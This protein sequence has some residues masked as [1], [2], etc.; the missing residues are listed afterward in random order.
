MNA[1]LRH[2]GLLGI[3]ALL[4]CATAA[5]AET[6]E[7]NGL[8]FVA[9]G[10][11]ATYTYD[12]STPKLTLTGMGPY[13]L[14][15]TAQTDPRPIRILANCADGVALTISNLV[16]SGGVPL[17]VKYGTS[18]DLYI[19]GSNN[20]VSAGPGIDVP[21]GAS[22]AIHLAPGQS[23]ESAVLDVQG[24]TDCAGI[25]GDYQ[26]AH[27]TITINGGTVVARAG[28][29]GAGIG[30]GTFPTSGGSYTS[31]AGGDITIH[32]GRVFAYGAYR[33]AGIGGGAQVTFTGNVRITDG[34]VKA[35]GAYAGIGSGNPFGNS[36]LRTHITG[37]NVHPIFTWTAEGNNGRMYDGRVYDSSE[38]EVVAKIHRGFAPWQRVVVSGCPDDYGTRQLT[39]NDDGEVWLFCNGYTTVTAAT[40]VGITADGTDVWDGEGPGW[41]YVSS[42]GVLTLDGTKEVVLSGEGAT[43]AV[44][45]LVAGGGE[46]AVTLSNL[47]VRTRGG[48]G[49]SA[50]SVAAGTTAILHIAGSNRL[51]AA[52]YA[53]GVGVNAG[54]TVI[55]DKAPGLSDGDVE[56]V[57]VG[58]EGS[59]IGARPG[60]NNSTGTIEIRGGTIRAQTNSGGSGISNHG[61]G[62]VRI[63][64]GLVYAS[65]P[66]YGSSSAGIGAPY[67]C[68]AGTTIISGGTVVAV[69]AASGAGIGGAE[70]CNA[71]NVLITGGRVTATGGSQSAGIGSAFQGTGG[72][73]AIAGGTVVAGSGSDAPAQNGT[74]SSD[75]GPG[76]K[77]AACDVLIIGGS[78][79][80][81]HGMVTNAVDATDAPLTCHE[82]A[83][84]TPGAAYSLEGAPAGYGMKDIFADEAGKI[85]VWCPAG[86]APT[87]VEGAGGGSGGWNGSA[88]SGWTLTTPVPVP[89]TWLD[90]HPFGLLLHGGDYELFGNATASNG[91]KVWECYVADLDPL[92]AE[93][94]LVA[95]IVFENGLPKVTIHKGRSAARVYRVMG[96]TSPGAAGSGTDVTDV[97]DLTATPYR[98][99]RISVELPQSE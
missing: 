22:L 78:V 36:G 37:G 94:D 12:A 56:L 46:N 52:Y 38:R 18:L 92:N 23:N 73:V 99:F 42:T 75:I 53:C 39:A 84:L 14:S 4:F 89:H 68:D 51:E 61:G 27:G 59:G 57:A 19:A 66:Q 24:G 63:V 98:F 55:I 1:I 16:V 26:K 21:G 2:S 76:G 86:Y 30:T 80:G 81:R 50:L 6:R 25:G 45:I 10:N 32:G 44:A 9:K 71:G 43:N 29:G 93:S 17:S 11:A 8:T 83:G 47:V 28:Y 48:G 72:H 20:L 91:R 5:D 74:W 33:G 62:T 58:H 85:Y 60:T 88:G 64:G 79:H 35:Q 77:S 34:V 65:A 69:G 87:A 15:G 90:R 54:A 96:W 49:R 41:S 40:P 31:C 70:R 13:F 3:T 95:G 67:G 82:I 97:A 7:I